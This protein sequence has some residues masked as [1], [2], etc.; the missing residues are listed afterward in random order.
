MKIEDIKPPQ[1]YARAQQLIGELHAIRTEMG[2]S[3]DTRPI[4]EITNAQP[5][6]C[7]FVAL[8]VWHKTERL[9][10]ELGAKPARAMPP[11]PSPRDALPGHV[12]QL[13]D[14][15]LE[16]VAEI[17]QRLGI[18]E[19][20][21]EPPIESARVPSD[22]LG[23]LLHATRDLSR[24]MERPFAPTDVYRVVSLASAYAARMGGRP[25]AA[26]FQRGRR[27]A[28]CYAQLERCLKVITG[29]IAKRDQ[30]AL[31]ERGTP[32]DVQPGDVY[33]LAMIVLGELAFLHSLGSHAPVQP[34]ESAPEGVR[35]PAHVHQL[36]SILEAQLVV[37]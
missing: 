22:V 27:P 33:D 13:I 34:F 28:D 7:Y 19:T 1:C 12:L 31:D 30:P 15:A 32:P 35:L 11:A 5:R 10:N 3:E 25:A 29:V 36:A 37:L 21:R 8:A 23:V 9:A 4:P 14:G 2:R 26:P 24:L 20:V 16:Q 6:E 17:K 18:T